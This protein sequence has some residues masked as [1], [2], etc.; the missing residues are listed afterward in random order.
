MQALGGGGGG[1]SWG[2]KP[3]LEER[4]TSKRMAHRTV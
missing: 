4:E 1:Y 3:E 2:N